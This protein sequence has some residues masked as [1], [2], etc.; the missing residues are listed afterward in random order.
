MDQDQGVGREVRS[1]REA[2]GW[3]QTRLATEAG[4]SVSGISMI[5]NGHRNLSTATLARLAEALGVE[6]RDLFPLGQA[7]LPLEERGERSP[8]AWEQ[9]LAYVMEP[10]VAEALKEQQAANRFLSSSG[11]P[12]DRIVDPPE[13]EVGRR[14]LEQLSPEERPLA[15]GEVAL[16]RARFERDKATLAQSNAG[17]RKL[18]RERDREIA[19][20]EEENAQLREVHEQTKV[21]KP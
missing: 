10:V 19:R 2:R 5:E 20:L 15:F 12:Q 1:L 9:T 18:L 13:A 11:R 14:F 4:M 8:E 16:G 3:S 17:L 6:V 7:P 21:K